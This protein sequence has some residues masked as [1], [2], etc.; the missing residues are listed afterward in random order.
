MSGQVERDEYVL[1]WCLCHACFTE[2]AKRHEVLWNQ[3]E[4][5]TAEGGNGTL[6]KVALGAF[7]KELSRLEAVGEVSSLGPDG[8]RRYRFARRESEPDQKPVPP[9][10]E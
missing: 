7:K 10:G 9:K 3:F 4:I 2:V 8:E 6:W 1:E 5:V